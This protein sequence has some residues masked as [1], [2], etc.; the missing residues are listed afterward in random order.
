V[1]IERNLKLES[2]HVSNHQALQE[3]AAGTARPEP[4]HAAMG[5]PSKR[6]VDDDIDR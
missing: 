1:P 4:Q 6:V 3:L 2:E 5:A